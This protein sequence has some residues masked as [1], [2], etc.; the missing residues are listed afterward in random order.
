[1]SKLQE[2]IATFWFGD[3][4]V[5]FVGADDQSVADRNAAMR[6]RLPSSQHVITVDELGERI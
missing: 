2:W 3:E 5:L 4:T 6:R 1:M